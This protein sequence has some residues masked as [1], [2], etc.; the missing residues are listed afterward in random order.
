MVIRRTVTA[1][2]GRA[3]RWSPR[4]EFILYSGGCDKP[5]P[6]PAPSRQALKKRITRSSRRQQLPNGKGS[7]ERTRSWAGLRGTTRS[8]AGSAE[9]DRPGDIM[10]GEPNGSEGT[11][12][13]RRDG[14][15]RVWDVRRTGQVMTFDM[16]NRSIQGDGAGSNSNRTVH[17]R[18]RRHRAPGTRFE[19]QT[20]GG[21]IGSAACRCRFTV[22]PARSAWA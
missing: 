15:L 4:D 11:S 5:Q 14:A 16:E 8:A 10:R 22:E 19:M 1:R 6:K 9:A 18:R 12:L 3:V 21:A 7:H 17:P 13:G 20:Q 2:A